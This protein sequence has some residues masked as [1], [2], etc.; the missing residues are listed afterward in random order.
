MRVVVGGGVIVLLYFPKSSMTKNSFSRS[1][2]HSSDSSVSALPCIRQNY[3][4]LRTDWSQLIRLWK[5]WPE[6]TDILFSN[7]S[8]HF[9]L[10]LYEQTMH[11]NK[12]TRGKVSFFNL[13][14]SYYFSYKRNVCWLSSC[15][16]CITIFI[17]NN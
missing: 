16:R 2:F 13:L 4:H 9:S 15:I 1:V 17:W 7:T 5:K 11:I 14:G 8:K 6:I 3:C 12:I 10:P